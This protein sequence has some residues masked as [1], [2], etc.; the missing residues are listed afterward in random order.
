MKRRERGQYVQELVNEGAG[1]IGLRVGVV[2][3]A[4]SKQYTVCWE[5]GHRRRYP[6]GYGHQIMN[7]S[8]WSE[9]ERRVATDR[10]FQHC[11]I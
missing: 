4:G 1:I 11:G 7:W 9:A 2:T 5:S 3:H 6:Q 8:D 10:I